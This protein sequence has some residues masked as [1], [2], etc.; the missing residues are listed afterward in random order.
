M[1]EIE[2]LVREFLNECKG[3][4][5][6][7]RS[8]TTSSVYIKTPDGYSLRVGDHNGKEKYKY[9][10]NLGPQYSSLGEWKFEGAYSRFYC[11]CPKVIANIINNT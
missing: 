5:I 2:N 3:A 4:Y 9:K 8:V 1:K 6:H 10:Y 11:S 7:N